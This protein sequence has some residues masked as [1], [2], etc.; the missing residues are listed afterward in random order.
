MRF[1]YVA[2]GEK[3]VDVFGAQL[4]AFQKKSTTSAYTLNP[5]TLEREKIFGF[6]MNGICRFARDVNVHLLRREE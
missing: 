1:E 5:M 4:R 3:F 2:V 6:N